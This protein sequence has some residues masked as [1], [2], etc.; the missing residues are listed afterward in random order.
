M[1]KPDE[2]GSIHPFTRLVAAAVIPFLLLAFLIL[3]FFPE[4]SA[5][6]FAWNI[7]PEIMGLYIGAGY[8]GGSY[9]FLRTAMGGRWSRVAVGFPA[10]SSFT[11]VMLIAT[12]IHWD[13]FDIHHFP[14]QLWLILYVIT[15]I[16]VPF[17]W[18]RQRHSDDGSVEP[19]DRVVP[20]AVRSSV[21][22][23]GIGIVAVAC[24][25]FVSPALIVGFWPWS[26]SPL[27]ARILCGW[28]ILLGI[29]NI[30]VSRDRRWSAWRIGVESIAIWHA[31][32]LVG[33]VFYRSDFTNGRWINWYTLSVAVAL[34]LVAFFF[35][36]ISRSGPKDFARVMS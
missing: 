2:G 9:L 13:R 25:G 21:M 18:W 11:L 17:L 24:F 22:L 28:G 6:R 34:L 7:R 20:M 30:F 16:L 5:E 35:V 12:I 31:L 36:R 27:M 23:L 3:Y 10:V 15:P 4:T 19:G 1:S 26:L 32:F 8:L 33:T 29:G 14:F